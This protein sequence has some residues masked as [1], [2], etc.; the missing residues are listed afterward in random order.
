MDRAAGSQVNEVRSPTQYFSSDYVLARDRFREAAREY[1]AQL[2]SYPLDCDPKLTID[3]AVRGPDDA[4]NAVVVSSGLHGIEGFFG[5]A[6]QL[7]WLS[8]FQP[9]IGSTSLRAVWIH[10]INPYG[11]A[12]ERRW[13]EDN[14]DLNRN[15]L[16]EE[17]QFNGAPAA[18]RDL[19]GLLNPES[20]PS[21]LEPFLVKAI[22]TIAKKGLP[23]LKQAI[24]GG[25]YDYP[26]GLFFGGARPCQ[27]ARIIQ[28][29]IRQWIGQASNVV[30]LDLHTGLG[31]RGACKLLLNETEIDPWY[32][33]TFRDGLEPTSKGTGTAYD[34]SGAMGHWL[35]QN[36]SD[37]NYRFLLAEFGTC[38]V[39]R[40]L[41][42]LRAENRAHHYSSPDQSA[43]QNAKRELMECFCPTAES[44]REQVVRTAMRVIH[45]AFAARHQ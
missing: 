11:F 13:N 6:V 35:Q 42:A 34:S 25:Q 45:L 16:S 19:N 23:A 20:P 27:S 22:W 40:V 9:L 30:H 36:L 15:F 10:A 8:E 5:S 28:E 12:H 7:A 18:Y 43:Y 29:N 26:R 41:S 38:G 37:L 24:A 17:S 44:W 3:V 2:H 1:G 14:V 33:Q 21:V 32:V 4:S 39:V 31:K